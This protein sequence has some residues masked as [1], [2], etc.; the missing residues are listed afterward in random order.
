VKSQL[1]LGV[2]QST[3]GQPEAVG[4]LRA[5]ASAAQGLGLLPLVWPARAVLGAVLATGEESATCLTAARMVVDT[6]AGNL[7]SD[8]RDRWL[9]RPDIVALHQI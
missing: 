2:A 6:L 4:T 7:P 9:A 3:A 1:F 8:V 5:A